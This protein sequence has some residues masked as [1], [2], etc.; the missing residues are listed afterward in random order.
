V[1]QNSEGRCSFT[2]RGLIAGGAVALGAA[3]IAERA[4]GADTASQG[5]RSNA[6]AIHQE[7]TLSASPQRIFEVLV[8]AKKFAAMTGLPARID[9]R[10][11]GA[12]SLFGGVIF[13]RNLDET[14][15]SWLVQAWGDKN[16]PA[17]FYSLVRFELKA[18]GAGTLLILDHRDI[19]DDPDEAE[20]L[21]RGWKEH[22][23]D[24]LREFLP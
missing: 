23:W 2:R 15:Y 6:F 21:A 9:P 16:W 11:G 4:L 12:F 5:V 24:L 1:V 18:Q 19:P 13:G 10:A 20:A 7:E 14:P 8:N 3:A 22:Y 17:G